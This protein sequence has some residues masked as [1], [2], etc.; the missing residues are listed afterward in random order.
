M[1]V[2]RFIIIFLVAILYTIFSVSFIDAVYP[3]PEYPNNCYDARPMPVVQKDCTFVQASEVERTTCNDQKGDLRPVY[4]DG[5][6]IT[7][8]EC[9]MCMKSH[10]AEQ[11]VHGMYSF[12]LSAVLALVA[13]LIG[14]YLPVSNPLNEWVG[15]GFILGG[16][17]TLFFGTAAYYAHL[18][19][20]WRPVIM[21]AELLLVL[22]VTYRKINLNKDEGTEKKL[23]KKSSKKKR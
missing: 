14:L 16:L 2:R 9:S 8:Y 21:L 23:T 5:G 20:I 7:S 11:D 12:F 4:G 3:R 13:I 19:R 10:R 15:F 1:D 22:F 6:C 18:G 17:F